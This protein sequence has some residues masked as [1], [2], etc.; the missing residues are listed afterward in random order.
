MTDARLQFHRLDITW[1]ESLTAFERSVFP[2]PWSAGALRNCLEDPA[3]HPSY[4]LIEGSRLIAYC[5]CQKVLDEA[6]IL[7][8]AVLPDWRNRGLGRA[9]LKFC[10]QALAEQGVRDV[11]LEVRALNIPARHCYEALGYELAGRRKAYY[12]DPTDDALLYHLE[13]PAPAKTPKL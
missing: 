9:F 13:L 2:D 10:Q 6:E 3:V 12:H 7:R 4:G 11:H 1:L 8:V 5:L